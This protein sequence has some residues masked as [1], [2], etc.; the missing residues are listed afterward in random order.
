MREERGIRG[1][2]YLLELGE[3]LAKVGDAHNISR[4]AGLGKH[5]AVSELGCGGT[6]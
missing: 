3:E 2:R 1:R 4:L 6:W 5:V